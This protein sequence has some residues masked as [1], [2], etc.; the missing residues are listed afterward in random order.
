MR[1]MA[2]LLL[3]AT[4]AIGGCATWMGGPDETIY[5]TSKPNHA[6]VV[7]QPTG[8]TLITPGF[9]R[10]P[11][12]TAHQAVF[13]AP[14]HIDRREIIKRTVSPWIMGNV[15]TGGLGLLIDFVSSSGWNLPDELST[16]LQPI[17]GCVVEEQ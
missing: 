7:F 17:P 14:C 12:N 6:Y 10:L 16:V 3:V 15:V 13:S 8:F 5:V 9:V 4:L 11:K 2:M 1:P